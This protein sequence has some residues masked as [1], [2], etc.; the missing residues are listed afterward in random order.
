MN[1]LIL[2]TEKTYNF[3]ILIFNDKKEVLYK[4]NFV[5]KERFED[6]KIC[7]EQTYNTKLK[8]Y[9]QKD[10]CNAISFIT[11]LKN[12]M[13]K[14]NIK[15][16][17]GH[18]VQ[19]D[20]RNLGEIYIATKPF[21]E[22]SIDLFLKDF[23]YIYFLDSISIIKL[24]FN[25]QLLNL[26]DIIA[27]IIGF[28]YKQKHIALE[29]C[30]LLS[31]LLTPFAPY[32]HLFENKDELEFIKSI[33]NEK[34]MTQHIGKILFNKT[35][36]AEDI[37]EPNEDYTIKTLNTRLANM[38]SLKLLDYTETP[39]I[40]EATGKPLKTMTKIYSH[41][42]TNSLGSISQ[43][44]T[45]SRNIK[46][47]IIK[48]VVSNAVANDTKINEEINKIKEHYEKEYENKILSVTQREKEILLKEEKLDNLVSEF[49]TRYENVEKEVKIKLNGLIIP[50]IELAITKTGIFGK[51]VKL[52]LE[53]VIKDLH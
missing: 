40:S 27:D 10:F 22:P 7:G 12:V 25:N 28:Q 16:I 43:L 34:V 3:G 26:E 50:K 19:E 51:E 41:N 30:I 39:K 52:I 37:F 6:R 47:E 24:L 17:I 42:D 33:I 29:D 23:D 14:Y 2:D 4:K 36:K 53:E 31:Y 21:L 46:E 5:I 20:K 49:K 1:Y 44:L 18:N 48:N 13:S 15:T 35:F 8:Y 9:E 45:N 32:L 11:E 38:C